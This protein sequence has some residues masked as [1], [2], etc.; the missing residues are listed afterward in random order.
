MVN[1]I[2]NQDASTTSNLLDTEMKNRIGVLTDIK[3]R[4]VA[5]DIFGKKEKEVNQDGTRE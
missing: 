1:S 4:E 2:L 3:K 5:Q